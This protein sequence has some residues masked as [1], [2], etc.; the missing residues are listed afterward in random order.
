MELISDVLP[1]PVRTKAENTQHRKA[2][3][4][5]AHNTECRINLDSFIQ[6]HTHKAGWGTVRVRAIKKVQ[7]LLMVLF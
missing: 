3:H 6:T 1:D 4:K 5:E 7:G 2:Q